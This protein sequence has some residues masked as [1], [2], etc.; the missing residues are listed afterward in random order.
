VH[1]RKDTMMHHLAIIAAA[2]AIVA[3]VLGAGLYLTR[4]TDD[5]D[6]T[7]GWL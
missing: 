1:K 2:A 4:G 6:E 7:E 5:L 3:A